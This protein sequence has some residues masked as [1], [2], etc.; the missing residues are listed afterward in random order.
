LRRHLF[1]RDAG[2]DGG[3]EIGAGPAKEA[4]G[5]WISVGAVLDGIDAGAERRVDAAGAVLFCIYSVMRFY[6][7]FIGTVA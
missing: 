6:S 2:E 4:D 1:N 3:D 7:N 5:L